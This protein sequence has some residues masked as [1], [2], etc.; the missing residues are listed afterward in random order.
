MLT[1]N[2][3]PGTSADSDE[4]EDEDEDEEEGFEYFVAGPNTLVG[5]EVELSKR[6]A[7]GWEL[8]E[9]YQETSG[10]FWFFGRRHILIFRRAP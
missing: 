8:V 6:A 9:A 1:R 5:M 4:D 7:E 2:N 10:W 3:D